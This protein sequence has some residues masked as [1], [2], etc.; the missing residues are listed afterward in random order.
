MKVLANVLQNLKC[1]TQKNVILQ[2]G[3]SMYNLQ[4]AMPYAV[5]MA[6]VLMFL[7]QRLYIPVTVVVPDLS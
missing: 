1:I 6:W 4:L 5:I 2:L 3:C 7:I